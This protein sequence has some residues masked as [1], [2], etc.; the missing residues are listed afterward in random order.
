MTT[1]NNR[2]RVGFLSLLTV[3]SG[4][5]GLQCNSLGDSGD[6][7]PASNN[8]GGA[9]GGAGVGGASGGGASA[10]GTPA[11]G[12]AWTATCADE[13]PEEGFVDVPPNDPAIRYVG[14]VNRT[15]TAVTFAFPAV[16]IQTRFQG[17]AIDMRLRDFGKSTLTATNFY[18]VLVDDQEPV[19]IETCAE[20]EVYPLARDLSNGEHTLTIVKRTESGPGGSPNSGKG[21]FLGFRIR[22]D[23]ELLAVTPPQ[24]RLEFVGD[25]IT[26]GYG[27][28]LS[29]TDPDSYKFTAVNENAWLAFS[30]VTAR[31]LS[32]DYVAIAASGRGVIR[33]Y[34]GFAG[35]LVPAMY[36][37]TLP[38]DPEFPAWDHSQYEPDVVVINLGTND[39]S[40]GIE[41]EEL[42][43]HREAFRAGYSEFL[44]HIRAVHPEA[45]IVATL[46]PMMG[47]SWPA[48]YQAWTSIQEDLAL[49]LAER[50][51]AGDTN[52]HLHVFAPQSS[53]Y[54]EDWH[55][56]IATHQKMADTLAPFIAELS[57]W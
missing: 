41:L 13:P 7:D 22:P 11:A 56:T 1:S 46:G 9:W 37:L 47:D 33:N 51:A 12:G 17:D 10:G 55:P 57:G 25:S 50:A 53:P 42:P 4:M 39:Y 16:H 34:G 35:T 28:E 27:N 15:D 40:P 21:E 2:A 8:Q 20:R 3:L 29:T 31:A 52:V 24:R 19:T 5:M 18:E 45:T 48:G 32:A 6:S 54:G 36:D 23:T 14:R 26:C 38:E 44:T 49:V 43:A 30:A